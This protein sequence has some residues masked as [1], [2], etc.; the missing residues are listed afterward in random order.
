MRQNLPNLA[1]FVVLVAGLT[2][3]WWYV[4]KTFFPKPVPKPPEPPPPA[5]EWVAALTGA[6]AVGAGPAA[7]LPAL[8]PP[9][10]PTRAEVVSA[11][12]G[13]GYLIAALASKP[14]TPPPPAAPVTLF[15]LGDPSFHVSALLTSRGGGVQQVTLQR[16]HEGNRLGLEVKDAS[17][18]PLP[19]RLI[20]GVLQPRDKTT[21][22]VEAPFP[23]LAP[24]KVADPGILEAPS[25]VVLHYPSKDDPARQAKDAGRMND[26]YP[27][28]ELGDR[29]WTLVS[30]DRPAGGE[31]KVVFET[32]LA[33]PYF[34]KLRKTFT[35]GPKDYH[36]GFKFDVEPLPERKKGSG[37]FRYQLT[38]PRALP[39]E[40][41]WFAQVYRNALVGWK[42]PRG[43]ARRAYEDAATVHNLGGGDPV[44]RGE[45]VITYMGVV[46]QYFASAAAV[47]DTA[48]GAAVSPWEYV[49]PTRE[50]HPWD[51]PAHLFLSDITVR[52][53]ARPLDPAPGE[54]VSHKYLLYN[55]PAKVR[56]LAQLT[57]DGA[58]APELV[59]R[60]LNALTLRTLTDYHS[61]N[62]FG[63]LANAIWWSDV[64]IT[65]TNLMHE[66]LGWL[67]MVVPVWGL[68]IIMLT[69]LVRLVLFFPS[70]KQQ[71]MML[72]MQEKMAKLK[73][74]I[75][76]LTEKYKDDP[77]A[78][79]QAKM[80]LMMRNGVNPL[81]TTG[82]CLLLFA[83][84]PIFMGLY[85][86]LQ[87]SVFFRH[88]PF[89]WCPNLAAPDMLV[90]WSE[91]I[92]FIS[93]LE[94]LGGVIY[95]GPYLNILPIIA[96]GLIFL[97]QHITMPPPTDEQQEMQQKMMKVMVVV[98]AVFFY[99]V[100]AGLTL[101]FIC[102]TS[103]ALME[104]Q[105]IPKPK[106]G[107]NAPPADDSGQGAKLS[108]GG[109]A[110]P[111]NG[112]GGGL[113]SRLK[114]RMEER[115]AEMQRQADE[116]TRRQIRNDDNTPRGPDRRDRDKKKKRK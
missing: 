57:G 116:Q 88:E 97:Q 12:G 80:Q 100:P 73:P 71:T 53:V 96:T 47:D 5:R 112:A 67:N 72:R 114:E 43:G 40:G 65:F 14:T 111:A 13:G 115:L 22:T 62:F 20:P 79:Q 98:M 38:G 54:A 107:P 42:T 91:R 92:P 78:I 113:I 81:S 58:V 3:G 41:E 2:L 64:V 7:A 101:Y 105:L 10:P 31:H 35:L 26:D 103:W 32:A 15:A 99:K 27:S 68:N 110:G 6:L 60:Y 85:F 56:L 16:F 51:D 17:G 66:V 50:P 1:A 28:P 37:E 29:A 55:G 21:L 39:I 36:I 89:L 49:R 24:G 77:Q 95:L 18:K 75:D 93:T 70:R 59:D 61:P 63:R 19:M 52:G 30:E 33:A 44:V 69:V 86:C 104:R 109:G 102:S 4:E 83:Q 82:G 106:V 108:P 25:Y 84:M 9:L 11:V 90:W 23:D 8:P 45:N 87:E 94:N 46:T 48:T 76:K 74:E 34:L